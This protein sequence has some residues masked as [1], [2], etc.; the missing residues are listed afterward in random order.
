M[1]KSGRIWRF[2]SPRASVYISLMIQDATLSLREMLAV[3]LGKRWRRNSSAEGFCGRRAKKNS[4]FEGV[5][6][7]SRC[8]CKIVGQV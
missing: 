2:V 5:A 7:A 4:G 1:G 3:G 6:G 8:F